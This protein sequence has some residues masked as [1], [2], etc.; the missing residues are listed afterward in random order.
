M[1]ENSNN[2]EP[3]L[4]HQA[5][6][7]LLMAG[8][9]QGLPRHYDGH[10]PY[11]LV[12]MGTQ[13]QALEV[14][15]RN[16]PHPPRA[17]LRPVFRR[18]D[19]AIRYLEQWKGA[20]TTVFAEAATREVIAIIDY[21]APGILPQIPLAAGG[22]AR[23]TLYSHC[24]HIATFQPEAAAEW[25]AWGGADRT[26]MSQEAFAEFI[27]EHATDVVEPTA[28]DMIEMALAFQSHRQVTFKRALR[29]ESG[30]VNLTFSDEEQGNGSVDVPQVFRIQ[31]PL[32]RGM[33]PV[34]L[35]AR[36]RYRIRD[37]EL[38]MAYLLHRA[39]QRIDMAFSEMVQQLEDATALKVLWGAR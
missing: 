38:R 1:S 28:A 20:D 36:F 16:L 17:T 15:E 35:T 13:L 6:E 12:P 21:H 2:H 19:S 8:M 18:I 24:D 7:T 22:D 34:E 25:Q 5:V 39:E 32:F 3:G 31:I 10:K 11:A 27:E 9:H 33:D 4:G 30:A 26:W 37:G 29:L 14:D 23:D